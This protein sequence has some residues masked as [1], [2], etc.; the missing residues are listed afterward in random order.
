MSAHPSPGCRECERTT[1][2]N[3]GKHMKVTVTYYP[4]VQC[5]EVFFWY[6]TPVQCGRQAGHLGKHAAC[7]NMF[8]G[9]VIEWGDT[10]EKKYEFKPQGGTP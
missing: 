10:S 1:S 9:T 4:P 2:G 3:C 7:V 5:A 8:D 6:M